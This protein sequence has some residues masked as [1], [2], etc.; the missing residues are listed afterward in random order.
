MGG[1]SNTQYSIRYLPITAVAVHAHVPRLPQFQVA[2]PSAAILRLHST[3]C[4]GFYGVTTTTVKES[5]RLTCSLLPVRALIIRRKDSHSAVSCS[6]LYSAPD[7]LGVR[8]SQ[9]AFLCLLPH[10]DS[11]LRRSHHHPLSRQ[12][13]GQREG[14][15]TL[16]L[17]SPYPLVFPGPLSLL[18]SRLP[19]FPVSSPLFSPSHP[20]L[21]FSGPPLL[22]P[23]TSPLPENT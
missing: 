2:T 15:Q 6:L 21:P 8:S 18:V 10:S 1:N 5:S 13:L 20:S 14:G 22:C 9:R 17:L 7:E 12:P 19:S 23:I 16:L 11:H 4:S 3:L